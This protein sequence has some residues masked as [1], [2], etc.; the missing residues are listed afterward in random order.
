MPPLVSSSSARRVPPLDR[1]DAQPKAGVEHSSMIAEDGP[2]DLSLVRIAAAVDRVDPVFLGTPQFISQSLSVAFGREVLVKNE[3]LTPIGSFKGRGTWLLADKLDPSRTWVCATAGNFGQGLAYAA[4]AH[5]ATVDAFVSADVPPGKVERMRTLGARVWT[6]EQPGA[7]AREHVAASA[8]RLLVVDGLQPEMA[9]G[10]GT[11]GLEL[12]ASG[13]L[14]AAVVQI[15][16]GALISGIARW[17]KATT[18]GMRVIGVCASGAPAMARSFAACRVTSTAGTDTIATALAISE[19]VPESLARVIALV[20]EIVLVD[21]DDLRSAQRLIVESLGLGVEPAGA[22][23]IAALARHGARLP[24]GR[25]AV[26]LTGT[27][28][29]DAACQLT[30]R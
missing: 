10:A 29:V 23:G 30:W 16:D 2:T 13:P 19:P 18:P 25:T 7:A 14:D 20:D 22:A 26:L 21:D 11:I 1:D 17:L 6:S 9:E 4:R 24:A 3:T 12:E 27:G 8:G 5:G 28:A 15:G